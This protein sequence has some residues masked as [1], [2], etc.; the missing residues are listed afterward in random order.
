MINL[1]TRIELV[2]AL[3]P[4]EM[5][6]NFSSIE[7]TL[8]AISDTISN[9]SNVQIVDNLFDGG[10]TQALSAEQGKILQYSK[11]PSLSGNKNYTVDSSFLINAI[12]AGFSMSRA[13]LKYAHLTSQQMQSCD[14][15]YAEMDGISLDGAYLSGSNFSYGNMSNSYLQYSYAD[16]C[17]FEG[18][19]M[20]GVDFSNGNCNSSS[21][22]NAY[23]PS[24]NF[25]GCQ[26]YSSNL[27]GFSAP[28]SSFYSA[29]LSYTNLAGANFSNGDFSYANFSYGNVGYSYLNLTG[30]SFVET[31][32]NS[33][34]IVGDASDPTW[35]YGR[36]TIIWTDGSYWEYESNE[37]W[38][39]KQ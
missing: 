9:M 14:F 39:M 10:N 27:T 26:F 22:A 25:S 19:S 16:N 24:S 3:T 7:K 31:N 6:M 15:S 23:A 17:N 28:N 30:C 20:G 35:S 37:T 11:Y 33:L 12:N 13:N 29:G 32:P 36:P 2:R 5:D 1:L 8:N 34:G 38:T 21:F 4:T 18:A